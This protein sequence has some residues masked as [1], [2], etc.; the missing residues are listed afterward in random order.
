[1]LVVLLSTGM[2]FS[3]KKSSTPAPK[4]Y[5][6]SVKDKTWWGMLAYTGKPQEYY[7]V[8]F[9]TDNSLTWSQLSGDY[10][11]HWILDGKAL[12]ITF[13]GNT[14]EIKTGI[15]DNDELVN[16][17][18]NTTASDIISGKLIANP[19][20]TLDNTIWNGTVDYPSTLALQFSFKP[21]LQVVLNIEKS[22]IKTYTYTK[23]SSDMIFRIGSN[24]F[25]IITSAN[26]MKGSV[27][28]AAYTWQA[29]K[30]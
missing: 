9:N 11:G 22:A 23:S 6:A 12:T 26:T 20:T 25:G 7:S 18:D 8:H 2:L 21:G 19:A 29:T 4:D 24:F 5:V 30:Q 15:S 28:N 27:D 1:M 3:C 10:N 17:K 14:V 16:I 13:D